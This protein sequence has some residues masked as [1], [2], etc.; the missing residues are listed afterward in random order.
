MRHKYARDSLNTR[1]L[2]NWNFFLL[3]DWYLPY[4]LSKAMEERGGGFMPFLKALN[5]PHGLIVYSGK[6][7][8]R[9]SYTSWWTNVPQILRMTFLMLVMQDVTQGHFWAELNIWLRSFP[10][11]QTGCHIKVKEVSLPYCLPIADGENSW[12]QVIPKRISVI[13]NSNSSSRIWTR[14]LW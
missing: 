6:G 1:Q 14:L 12:I 4:Y 2:L 5:W 3:S 13:L 9:T 11:P 8:S 7:L 10:S